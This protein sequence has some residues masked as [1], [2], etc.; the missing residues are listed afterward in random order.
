MTLSIFILLIVLFVNSEGGLPV[1]LFCLFWCLMLFAGIIGCAIIR[2]QI[3]VGLRHCVQSA[4]KILLR[5]NI[6]AGIEDKGQLSC[7]KVVIHFIWFRCDNCLADIERLIRIEASGGAVVYSGEAHAA[8]AKE[9]TKKEVQEKARQL[10]L[11]YSQGYVKDTVKH[12]II[13]PSRPSH[14]VS[15]FVPKH[16]TKQLCLCQYIDKYH[17]NRLPRKWYSRF[18]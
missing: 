1:M 3:R 7:H 13:F 15:E 12:R 18:I 11:K 2:K 9:L 5:S 6:L 10:I 16:C 4:N 8:F 14:G 17:F